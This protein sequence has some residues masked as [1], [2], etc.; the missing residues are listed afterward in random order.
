MRGMIKIDHSQHGERV[1][2][3]EFNPLNSVAGSD[4]DIVTI[5]LYDDSDKVENEVIE[6]TKMAAFAKKISI[7]MPL[8]YVFLSGI[9]FSIQSLFVKLLSEEGFHGSFE[10]V[11]SRGLIQLIIAS[12]VIYFDKSEGKPSI[13]GDTP[14]VTW[15]LFLRS[16]IGFGGIAF[17]F[18][19][20][21][22]LPIGDATV[23]VMLSPFCASFLS[24]FII[25]E[26][27][28]LKEFIGAMVSLLGATLVA[29]P[30]FL[31]GGS[32][33]NSLG[34]IY[35]LLGS[36]TAGGAY[37][38]VRMLGTVVKMPWSNVCYAQAWGQVLLSIPSLYL[39]GQT[40]S[41]D[42]TIAQF[43][44]IF[45]GGFIGAFSQIAM[46]IGMQREKSSLATMMR[47]SDI[48]FGYIWQVLFTSDGISGLSIFGA[49]LVTF[50]VFFILGLK[51][52]NKPEKAVTTDDDSDE[53]TNK[54]IE[55]ASVPMGNH[56]ETQGM[57]AVGIDEQEMEQVD[58][59]YDT[60]RHSK[61]R[62]VA[63]DDVST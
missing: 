54:M 6:E 26:P 23:L 40:F 46:T 44:L 12:L 2:K 53:T 32:G 28:K 39:A 47:M 30:P 5:D 61:Y 8:I 35:S 15:I 48:I 4:E 21:E 11:F 62:S 3:H 36:L 38:T 10:I 18:M 43:A 16:V 17:S 27:W 50:S 31:F 9:G 49:V 42:L 29:K 60:A 33:T 34:V 41:A 25:G 52:P 45:F 59:E 22:L 13:C 63:K 14:Y 57:V 58:L 56:G 19:A 20:V 37:V 55:L 24:I 1:I 7:Y 51:T